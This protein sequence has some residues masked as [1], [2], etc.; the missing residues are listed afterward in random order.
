MIGIFFFLF[1]GLNL[2]AMECAFPSCKQEAKNFCSRCKQA[3]YCGKEHQKEDWAKHKTLCQAPTEMSAIPKPKT[4]FE[5]KESQ[6]SAPKAI[7]TAQGQREAL[8]SSA[9]KYLSRHE[10]KIL[11]V[12]CGKYPYRWQKS[13]DPLLNDWRAT[14]H[15]DPGEHNHTY[16]F[17]IAEDDAVEPDGLWDWQSPIP[18]ELHNK[19]QI[20]YLENLPPD[21]LSEDMAFQN[22]YHALI[23]GGDLLFDLQQNLL[24]CDDLKEVVWVKAPFKAKIPSEFTGYQTRLLGGDEALL[25]PEYKHFHDFLRTIH[26][27]IKPLIEG[28]GFKYLKHCETSNKFNNRKE[29]TL[30]VMARK[31]QA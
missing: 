21:V 17:T 2:N 28:Y 27:S 31:P 29:K 30:Q 11:I 22:A 15:T 7:G 23:P 10:R 3:R 16:A 14:E 19:F 25:G 18:E 6:S 5:H 4:S 24:Y 8:C 1:L 26:S 20:V 13:V 9:K 12:G